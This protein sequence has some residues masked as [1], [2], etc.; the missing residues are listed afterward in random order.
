MYIVGIPTF[1]GWYRQLQ[2]KPTPVLDKKTGG[3]YVPPGPSFLL[4]DTVPDYLL[5]NGTDKFLI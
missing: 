4:I 1:L 3:G 5:I 2:C